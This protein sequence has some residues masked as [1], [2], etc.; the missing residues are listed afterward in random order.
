MES[1]P[2]WIVVY[3]LVV[4]IVKIKGCAGKHEQRRSLSCHNHDCVHCTLISQKGVK[5][6][7]FIVSLFKDMYLF[8]FFC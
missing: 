7:G 8:I 1:C 2:A 3:V 5:L 4:M 6:N